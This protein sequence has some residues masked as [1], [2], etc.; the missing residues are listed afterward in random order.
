M[1]GKA[2]RFR[3]RTADPYIQISAGWPQREFR[4]LRKALIQMYGKAIRFQT[5]RWRAGRPASWSNR[6]LCVYHT[7]WAVEP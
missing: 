3:D 4:T 1:Y 7:T 2:V 5:S 6:V